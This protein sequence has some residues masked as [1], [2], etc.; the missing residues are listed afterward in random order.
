MASGAFRPLGAEIASAL[1]DLDGFMRKAGVYLLAVILA[2][3]GAFIFQTLIAEDDWWSYAGQGQWFTTGPI[4]DGRPVFAFISAIAKNGFPMHPFDTVLFYATLTLYVFLVFRRW[5]GSQWVRLLLVSLFLTSPLLIEHLHF[6]VNQIPLSV[7]LLL[8]SFWFLT[9]TSANHSDGGDVSLA[10]LLLGAIALAL[11]LTIRNELVFM[12]AGAAV[13]E[14]GRLI[15]DDRRQALKLLF[16]LFASLLLGGA[17]AILVIV[18]TVEVSGVPFDVSGNNGTAGLVSSRADFLQVLDRFLYYWRY[19]LFEPHYLFP[20]AAKVLVWVL[21]GVA[22]LQAVVARDWLRIAVLAVAGLLLSA[23]PLSLGL[24]SKGFPYLYAAVFPLALFPCFIA[25]L[26]VTGPDR[27][28]PARW[29]A[30][31]AGV[32]LVAMSAASLSE[33]QV[34]LGN[35]NRRDFSTMTQFLAEIRASGVAD[36]K[37]ALYGSYDDGLSISWGKSREQCSAFDCV[38]ALGP[39]LVLT[40]MERSPAART[41]QLTPE[42]KAALKPDL[43]AM[44]PG[45]STLI[46]LDR[47]R[48]VIMM[49]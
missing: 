13:I 1:R 22:L 24:L 14:L 36:W 37:V 41:F 12:V 10:A 2:S 28:K 34:R 35:L 42:E 23:M 45:S 8:L 16:P 26:A 25:C 19:Y 18:T 3:G 17:F 49:K 31:L 43:D 38:P 30:G 32:L 48:F 20:Y 47:Q 33:A 46:R 11:A 39:I 40:L 6:T 21:A 15:L 9:L 27:L 4:A 29:I 5:S 44:S 7:A